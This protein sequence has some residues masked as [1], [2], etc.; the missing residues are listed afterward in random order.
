M[1]R[2]AKTVLSQNFVVAEFDEGVV[3][4]GMSE[5]AFSLQLPD[6]V[7]ESIMLQFEQNNL[8]VTYYL[9]AQ[10]EP[11]SPTFYA[12]LQDKTSMLRTDYAL[13]LYK[14]LMIEEQK[15]GHPAGG[16]P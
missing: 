5:Y 16:T 2:L 15:L 1:T 10:L 11:R 13:Y 6:V 8:S 4:D 7:S 9:K 14:P 12:N 3:Q